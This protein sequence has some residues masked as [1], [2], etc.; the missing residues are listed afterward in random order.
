MGSEIN[1]AGPVSDKIYLFR[2][3]MIQMC[4]YVWLV[5]DQHMNINIMDAY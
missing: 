5:G 3:W 4:M 1:R 2:I